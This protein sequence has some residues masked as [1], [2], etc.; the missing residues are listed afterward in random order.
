MRSATSASDCQTKTPKQSSQACVWDTAKDDVPIFGRSPTMGRE[1]ITFKF[2]R[3]E[4]FPEAWHLRAISSTR[5]WRR[6]LVHGDDFF[7]VDRRDGR[8]LTL[9]L[10]Q[11]AYEQSKIAS[12]GPRVITISDSQFLREEHNDTATVES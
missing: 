4:D 3:L 9:S 1:S 11:G 2:W 7:I 5:T 10:L 8:K 6:S 12:F